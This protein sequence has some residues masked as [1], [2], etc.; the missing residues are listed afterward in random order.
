MNFP[1]VFGPNVNGRLPRPSLPG[2]KGETPGM[3]IDDGQEHSLTPVVCHVPPGGF[4]QHIEPVQPRPAVA[5]VI[6]DVS[7]DDQPPVVCE[8]GK[9]KPITSEH[10]ITKVGGKPS[11]TT[12][13]VKPVTARPRG[14]LAE[15]AR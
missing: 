13:P 2:H 11:G 3:P 14:R 1:V 7:P 9:A 15:P 4:E 6:S 8:L 5:H 10:L 12:H